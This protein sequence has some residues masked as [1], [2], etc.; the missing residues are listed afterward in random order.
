MPNIWYL[1]DHKSMHRVFDRTQMH[2]LD[3]IMVKRIHWNVLNT[4]ESY[5]FELYKV[6]I[7][8]EFLK[9]NSN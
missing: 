7:I 5:N 4:I 3:Y 6:Q 9:L 8:L 1:T 2:I